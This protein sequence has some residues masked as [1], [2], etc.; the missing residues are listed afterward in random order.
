MPRVQLIRAFNKTKERL[1]L[2]H[3]FLQNC[4]SET[5]YEKLAKVEFNQLKSRNGVKIAAIVRKTG[6]EMWDLFVALI[7]WRE[8]FSKMIDENPKNLLS[9][10]KLLTLTTM[11]DNE[12]SELK[13]ITGPL[14]DYAFKSLDIPRQ[15]KIIRNI[16]NSNGAYMQT[17]RTHECHNC[18][19]IGH[20]PAWA[21]PFPKNY[22]NYA[23][24][25]NREENKQFRDKQ[26]QRRYKNLVEKVGEEKAKEITSRKNVH[27]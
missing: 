19:K 7:E 3:N 20:G 18:L 17:I 2:L 1:K 22:E 14:C 24:W 4:D 13:K 12:L 16:L 9:A 26:N 21:C 11:K 6:Q 27:D 25:M 23:L 5:K 10:E 8:L 15:L